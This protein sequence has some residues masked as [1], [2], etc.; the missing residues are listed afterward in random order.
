MPV[1]IHALKNLDITNNFHFD[2][3]TMMMI[4]DIHMECHPIHNNECN[5]SY[6]I[7]LKLNATNKT[8]LRRTTHNKIV[9]TNSCMKLRKESVHKC[10]SVVSN[11]NTFVKEFFTS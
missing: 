4:V 11:Y 1:T 3:N 7:V 9:L 10:S 5:N 6:H 2:C 8:I